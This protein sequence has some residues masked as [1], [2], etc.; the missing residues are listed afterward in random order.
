MRTIISILAASLAFFAVFFIYP[1]KE[2]EQTEFD[3]YLNN[4][5]ADQSD[6]GKNE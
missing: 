4:E 6:M 2:A 1:K 5:E 3:E